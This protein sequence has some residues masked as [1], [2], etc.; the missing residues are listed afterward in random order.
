MTERDD[1]G[2]AALGTPLMALH[3]EVDALAAGLTATHGARLACRS[4]C[5]GC[6][7]D[8]LSVF[9]VEAE[10]IRARQPAV[11]AEPPG[12]EGS[13]AF[14]DG[15]GRCRIYPDRPYVCRTQGL[16]LEWFDGEGLRRD[17]CELNDGERAPGGV[18]LVQL[19]SE[20]CF[21]LGPFEARLATLQAERQGVRP[22]AELRR[23]ALR[24]LFE[25]PDHGRV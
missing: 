10:R 15:A 5:S 19:P 25:A 20:A 4:G 1:P 16:P 7:R 11:L 18:D 2:E 12:P 14:L 9:E 24:S 8:D 21:E 23:V 13:C 3:R 6:C 17:I 22:G